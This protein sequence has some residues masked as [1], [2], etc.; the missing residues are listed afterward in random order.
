MSRVVRTAVRD[1]G[2]LKWKVAVC[3]LTV[4]M[5]TGMG[6]WWILLEQYVRAVR[7]S[8]SNWQNCSI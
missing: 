7:A 1:L 3:L 8:G 5:F 2:T 4:F 6:V